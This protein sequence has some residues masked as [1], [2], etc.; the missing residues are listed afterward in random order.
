MTRDDMV[1]FWKQN[2]V[3]NNAALVV[4]G[5]ITMA[6]LRPLA[7][8]AFG[9][10]QRGTPARPALG[11]PATTAARVVIVDKPGR[12]A[13]AA[14]RR[15]DRRGALVAGLP[16]D[17]GDEHGAR[18]PVLEPH[19]H[20][21]ARGA[22]LHLRRQLAVRVPQGGRVRSRSA[23]GVRTDVT[24]AAVA[25]ILKEVR[26]MAAAAMTADEL[27]RA[28]DALAYSLPGAFE[29]SAGTAGELLER[30]Y[31]R[32]RARL[33]RAPTPRASMP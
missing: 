7:E 16:G 4:A 31:L 33:L 5:D 29:T 28:K 11:A 12:A 6:E 24:G 9:A 25:E 22:R 21:P 15:R 1:A 3:P 32:S 18:R 26:G 2:F 20:E 23:S 27:K 10:W 30:L 8:K 14:A 13:D 19:Q 17:A